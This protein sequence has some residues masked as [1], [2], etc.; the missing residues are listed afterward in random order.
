M[1]VSHETTLWCDSGDD[2]CAFWEMF[3]GRNRRKVRK[4]AK[5]YGWTF[6]KGKDYCPECSKKRGTWRVLNRSSKVTLVIEEREE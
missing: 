1:S 2:K 5:S 4:E 3:P 6:A